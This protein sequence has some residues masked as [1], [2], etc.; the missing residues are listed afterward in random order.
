MSECPDRNAKIPV[1]A[2]S[3]ISESWIVDLNRDTVLVFRQPSPEGYK[4]ERAFR[5]GETISLLAFPE[6]SLSVDAIFG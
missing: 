5:R 6:L 4:E 1:Y 3:G 2:E